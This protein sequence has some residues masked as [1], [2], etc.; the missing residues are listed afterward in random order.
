M[1]WQKEA[2][3]ALG[4]VPFFVRKRVRK[5]VEEEAASRGALQVSIEHVKSCQRKFLAN[6]EKEV[7]GFQVEQCFGQDGCPNQ[8][9]QDQTLAQKIEKILAKRNLKKFLKSKVA[10]P[11]KLHHQFR[12]SISDCPNSCSRPQIVDIG[13]I[14]ARKPSLDLELCTNCG[15]CAEVCRE[16]AIAVAASTRGP[17][18]YD[19]K[20]VNCGQCID[21]CLPGA[22][23]EARRGYRILIGGKLGRHPQLGVELKGIRSAR[24]V[25][26]TIECCLDHY[27]EHNICGERFGE[28]LNRQPIKID[29]A[30]T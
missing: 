28:I 29:H 25:L 3:Q 5:S 21:V 1:E 8:A 18:L 22:L 27:L 24:E 15:A 14:G 12:V 26:N 17:T 11:L 13:L 6:M 2:E 10:E 16:E 7:R 23:K 30:H 19:D 20:C 9:I 4:R